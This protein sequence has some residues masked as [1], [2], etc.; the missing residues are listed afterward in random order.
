MDITSPKVQETF[1]LT[2]DLLY[3]YQGLP[4][5][6]CLCFAFILYYVGFLNVIWKALRSL[7]IQVIMLL[8]MLLTITLTSKYVVVTFLDFVDCRDRDCTMEEVLGKIVIGGNP[9]WSS[10]G[11]EMCSDLSILICFITIVNGYLY[12]R[13]P[14]SFIPNWVPLIGLADEAL[15]TAFQVMAGLGICSLVWFQVKYTSS[16]LTH[17]FSLHA[18]RAWKQSSEFVV[19]LS[20]AEKFQLCIGV[21]FDIHQWLIE[22]L[23]W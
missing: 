5:L 10:E 22:I 1:D 14:Y 18:E 8:I 6:L 15:V 11:L 12:K 23:G 21:F 4:E 2:L 20:L 3:S 16:T 13:L 19:E 9:I 7:M 17:R